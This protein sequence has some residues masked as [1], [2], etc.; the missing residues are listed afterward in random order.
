M[1]VKPTIPHTTLLQGARYTSSA[2]TDIRDTWRRHGWV[3]LNEAKKPAAQA[4]SK[5][6]ERIRERA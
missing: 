6:E 2:A 3:P 1:E 5:T 4:V